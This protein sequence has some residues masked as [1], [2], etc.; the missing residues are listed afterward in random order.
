VITRIAHLTPQQ[1]SSS[2][3]TSQSHSALVIDFCFSALHIPINIGSSKQIVK[4][5]ID[6]SAGRLFINQNFAKNFEIN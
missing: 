6:S 2:A 5:L 3:A 4:T 1:L